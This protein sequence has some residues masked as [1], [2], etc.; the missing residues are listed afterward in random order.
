[1][2]PPALAGR[3]AVFNTESTSG[4][5]TRTPVDDVACAQARIVALGN[6][7][8]TWSA[9]TILDANRLRV[10]P[11]VIDSQV[12]FHEPGLMQKENLEAG[13]RGAVLG[14]ITAIFEMPNTPPLTLSAA[15]LQARL[16]AAKGRAWC[17]HAF[18]TGGSGHPSDVSHFKSCT[19]RSTPS[20]SKNGSGTFSA[21]GL[22]E[23]PLGASRNHALPPNVDDVLDSAKAI[24]AHHTHLDN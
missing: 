9:D 21:G 13:T 4:R 22:R 12:H 3:K 24:S 15:D 2:T 11:G 14:D 23:K 18:Y 10:L 1:M 6:L 20:G 16:D 17:D 7:R 5:Y 19:I 8:G